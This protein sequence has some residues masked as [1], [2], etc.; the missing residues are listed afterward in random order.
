MITKNILFSIF[1]MMI[2]L[3]SCS[4]EFDEVEYRYE[5]SGT[6]GNYSVT[7]QNADDNTQ[8]YGSVGSGWW[9]KWDQS[10]TRFLY[11][12][13][14]NNNESGNVT[15]KI[16]R[17]GKVLQTNTSEGGYTIATVSGEF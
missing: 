2:T 7:I 4:D 1:L 17:N 14:Q 6:S 9:Y 3:S 8:Q 5:V 16:I 10:G 11:V 13:A 15:V 12:S